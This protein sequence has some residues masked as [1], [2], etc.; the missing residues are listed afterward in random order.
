MYSG[1][2]ACYVSAEEKE[3]SQKLPGAKQHF[4]F[5]L[6]EFYLKHV[7][8]QDVYQPVKSVNF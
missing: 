5:F 8:R 3:Y 2:P 7:S 1:H 6:E 4:D